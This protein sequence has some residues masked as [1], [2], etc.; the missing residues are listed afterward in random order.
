MNQII[1]SY[2]F[3]LILNM[4]KWHFLFHYIHLFFWKFFEAKLVGQNRQEESLDSFFQCL[5]QNES[6][7][8]HRMEHLI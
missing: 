2:T 5:L 7:R 8:H 3:P 6:H 4:Q 1:F